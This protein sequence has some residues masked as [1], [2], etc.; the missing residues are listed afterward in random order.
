MTP[1]QFISKQSKLAYIHV[2]NHL[3]DGDRSLVV[4]PLLLETVNELLKPKGWKLCKTWIGNICNI[5]TL[6]EKDTDEF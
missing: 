3:E 6:E 2:M 4:D 1:E 5:L